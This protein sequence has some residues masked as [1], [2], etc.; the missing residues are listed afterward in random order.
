[1]SELG[2][3][4]INLAK[5][6]FQVCRVV[7]SGAPTSLNRR[8]DPLGSGQQ[9]GAMRRPKAAHGC[10]CRSGGQDGMDDLGPDDEGAGLSNGVIPS[11]KARHDVRD[12]K[13][14]ARRSTDEVSDTDFKGQDGEPNPDQQRP[15]THEPQTRQPKARADVRAL[16]PDRSCAPSSVNFR[17]S[18]VL[19]L[20]A[21]KGTRL[22]TGHRSQPDSPSRRNTSFGAG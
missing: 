22:S 16:P 18:N 14:G 17:Q 20:L 6:R 19:L 7:G 3:L 13:A 9:E 11:R 4:A 21:R 8:Q 15:S 1:M 2:L 10:R 12:R 5:N